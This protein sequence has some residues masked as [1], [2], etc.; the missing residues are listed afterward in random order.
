MCNKTKPYNGDFRGF[1]YSQPK[2]AMYVELYLTSLTFA[3]KD[4]V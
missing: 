4:M 1:R 3:T 2:K